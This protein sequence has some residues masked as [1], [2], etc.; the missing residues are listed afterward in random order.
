VSGTRKYVDKCSD[1][2]RHHVGAN[3]DPTFHFD[4]DPDP[5]Y[6]ATVHCLYLSRQHQRSHDFQYCVPVP[7]VYTETLLKKFSLA[8][9]LVDMNTDPDP[10]K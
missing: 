8:L 7:C 4:A 9:H 5:V 6:T 2:D 10:A 1:V 3:P